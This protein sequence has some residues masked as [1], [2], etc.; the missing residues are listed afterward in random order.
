MSEIMPSASESSITDSSF[1][2]TCKDLGIK[3]LLV[4][5][6]KTSTDYGPVRYVCSRDGDYP[7]IGRNLLIVYLARIL[8]EGEEGLC[9]IEGYL[10]LK[11]KD[12]R[13]LFLDSQMF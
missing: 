10:W 12:H 4:E 11:R 6:N 9:R 5:L 1:L 13:I 2:G 3:R 7:F 8:A